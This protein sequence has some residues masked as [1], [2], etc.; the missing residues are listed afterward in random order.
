[1]NIGKIIIEELQQRGSLIQCKVCNWRKYSKEQF[2]YCGKCPICGC[3]CQTM[4]GYHPIFRRFLS[5]FI[6]ASLK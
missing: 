6:P 4:V 5:R 3:C 2:V 1:M